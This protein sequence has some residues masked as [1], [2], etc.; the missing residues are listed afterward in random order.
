MIIW[1][2]LVVWRYKLCLD[3]TS[4]IVLT[5]ESHQHSDGHP[6][7]SHP[8]LCVFV[9]LSTKPGEPWLK[10]GV[11][12]PVRLAQAVSVFFFLLFFLLFFSLFPSQDSKSVSVWSF[13]GEL[14]SSRRYAPWAES[15]CLIIHRVLFF[16]LTNWLSACVQ[17]KS[18]VPDYKHC[19]AFQ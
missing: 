18:S 5:V 2:W 6:C 14:N 17:S 19:F 7:K 4:F 8:G 15:S 1:F 16:F 10:S 3:V 9:E 11:V 13:K 12:M